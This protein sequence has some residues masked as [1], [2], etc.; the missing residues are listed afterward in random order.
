MDNDVGNPLVHTAS[1]PLICI[2]RTQIS[3]CSIESKVGFSFN[4]V[5]FCKLVEDV[6]YAQVSWPTELGKASLTEHQPGKGKQEHLFC[7]SHQ[8][9][10]SC[11][12]TS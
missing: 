8:S 6:V 1:F 7:C 10:H 12:G 2:T 9:A 5:R 11:Q 3:T 4:G